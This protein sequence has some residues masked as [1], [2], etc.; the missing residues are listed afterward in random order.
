VV[1]GVRLFQDR[2]Q[3]AMTVLSNHVVVALFADAHS[4]LIG[5]RNLVMP[6][7][8]SNFHYSELKHVVVVGDKEYIKK[9]W[10]N[11]CNFPKISILDVSPETFWHAVYDACFLLKGSP[12]NRANLRAVNIN[13]CDMCV[14]LSA[15]KSSVD[16]LNLVDKE[17]ILC[18]LN[19]KAMTFDDTVGL[20]QASAQGNP[21][22][23]LS[24]HAF[25][26][27]SSSA[28]RVLAAWV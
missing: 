20:L 15:R 28:C 11:L 6:L 4:P 14:I 7:R 5:L 26:Y 12:L 2:E 21:G 9:E 3:A 10:K 18:S 22:A 16:D 1:H 23:R 24:T 25:D 17:A 19:I 13:L 27:S 8:A